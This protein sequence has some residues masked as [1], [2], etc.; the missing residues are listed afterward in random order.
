MIK[1]HIYKT[2]RSAAGKMELDIELNIQKGQ[3]V[4][5]YG[6]SGAGKTSTLR[7]I[8]GLLTP[9]KGQISVG[10]TTWFDK[11]QKIN[12][13]TQQRKIGYVFQDYALFPNMSVRKNLEYAL[14]KKQ[15]KNI[16]DELISIVE[17]EEL[18]NRKPET[19]SGGQQQRVAL[20][21][22]LVR[23]PEVLLLDEPLSALDI[24]MRSKLQDYI[25]K[26]HKAYHLTTILVSHDIGEIIKMSDMIYDLKDGRIQKVGEPM[27]IFTNNQLSGK[28]QFVGDVIAISK[29]DVFYI[30]TVLI[31]QSVVKV[32][33]QE[34][35][36]VNLKI[37]DKVIVASKAFNPV[38]QKIEK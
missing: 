33:A 19:L 32:V 31:G 15:D 5:L 8:A 26:V 14:E 36:I 35:E 38:L 9:D 22:A 7:I 23:Q 27:S 2:L 18:Q 12:S 6:P 21:R 25:L 1:A 34:K 11:E 24:N 17:L 10:D 4:T 16:I 13:P 37:G 30:V 20:A 3:F 28:F 29:Q